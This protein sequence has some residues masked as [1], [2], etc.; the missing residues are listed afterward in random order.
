MNHYQ[1]HIKILRSDQGGE[2]VNTALE[3]YC[4][5]FGIT[6]EFTVPHTPEQN[7]IT[8]H[9]NQK[10]LDKGRTIMKDSS[11]PDF[12]WADAFATAVYAIN[13]MAGS[14]SDSMTPFKAFF[15]EKPNISHMHVWYSNM[16][17]HQPKSLGAVKLGEHGHQVKFLRYLDNSTGYRTYDPQ[18][19]KVQV[20]HTPIFR[21]EACPASTSSFEFVT[22]NSDSEDGPGQ[23][24]MHSEPIPTALADSSTAPSPPPLTL[25]HPAPPSAPQA[26]HLAQ[27][28]HALHHLDPSEFGPYGC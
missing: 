22:S 14:H 18:T 7:G 19:H 27:E 13:R 8:E 23:A 10:I 5:K 4:A 9:A 11:A 1:S 12:L 15:G 16:F 24:P 21:E 3:D 6:M 17:I 25:V 28:R 20:V 2:Y 26:S